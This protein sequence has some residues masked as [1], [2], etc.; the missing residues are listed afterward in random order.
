M[1]VEKYIS[2]IDI[3]ICKRNF[4]DSEQKW[5]QK[6]IGRQEN[7]QIQTTEIEERN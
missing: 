7:I 3:K 1:L 5:L 6:R 2:E 4:T